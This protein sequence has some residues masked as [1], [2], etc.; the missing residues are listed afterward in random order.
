MNFLKQLFKKRATPIEKEPEEHVPTLTLGDWW[1]N[2]FESEERKTRERI[3][4]N[5]LP[6]GVERE[7]I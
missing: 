4:A 3:A 5:E 7:W 6:P 2:Q 1:Q